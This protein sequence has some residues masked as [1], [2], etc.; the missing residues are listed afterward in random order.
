VAAGLPGVDHP[1]LLVTA[2]GGLHIAWVESTPAGSDT[3][4][5]IFYI[6]SPDGG[7]TWNE[8]VVMA[9]PGNDWPR[10]ALADGKL[11]L[12]FAQTQSGQADPSPSGALWQRTIDIEKITASSGEASSE[13]GWSP[14][15]RIPGW[16]QV[17]LPYGV[18]V[19]GYPSEGRLHLAGINSMGLILYSVWENEN[20]STPETVVP[21][22]SKPTSGG[23][24]A[25]ARP[26]GD[27]LAVAWLAPTGT[28]AG[29][30]NQP[31]T[32]QET[33]LYFLARNITPLEISVTPTAV[34]TLTPTPPP[35]PTA[36]TALPTPTP[37]LNSIPNPTGSAQA[38][39]IIGILF[40]FVLVVGF[41]AWRIISRRRR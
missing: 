37:D 28:G 36:T 3:A 22:M 31:A 8:P 14:A 6:Y 1:A 41:F 35:Q 12:I 16:D 25:A 24:A 33:G 15:M 2:E 20:W 26:L 40:P 9:G 30:V 19:D 7:D 23:L 38:P 32:R 34:P 18:T 5:R 10:L 17:N 29:V 21:G 11:H 39:L 4:Q 13:S 27:Q